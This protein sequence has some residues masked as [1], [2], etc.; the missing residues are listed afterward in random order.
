VHGWGKC[1]LV[2]RCV[3]IGMIVGT[4]AEIG[5][6][7]LQLWMYRRPQYPVVNVVAVFGIIMGSLAALV[8]SIGVGVAFV[9]A[10]A[11]GL[12]YEIVNLAR[13]HWWSFPGERVAFIH[14]HAAVVMM[15]ALL[16]GS[17]PLL[18]A[19]VRAVF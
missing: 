19:S 17:V 9:I 18:I 8:P 7:W 15:M 13:L 11:V 12:L 10:F 6:R 14:G 2:L 16:W 5:A 1:C 4:V 3:I